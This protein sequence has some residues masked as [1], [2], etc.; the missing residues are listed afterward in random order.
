MGWRAGRGRHTGPGDGKLFRENRRGGTND[1]RRQG[2]KSLS[3]KAVPTILRNSFQRREPDPSYGFLSRS[4]ASRFPETEGS[5]DWVAATRRGHAS[6]SSQGRA[7]QRVRGTE[8]HQRRE[9]V[10]GKGRLPESEPPLAF[11]CV[12]ATLR[13]FSMLT[14]GNRSMRHPARRAFGLSSGNRITWP[15][16]RWLSRSPP[17]YLSSPAFRAGRTQSGRPCPPHTRCD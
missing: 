3:A 1:D 10:G 15:A 12:S 7:S 8:N 2:Q 9:A 16:R 11:L 4:Y 6:S 13:C 5:L 17:E 14:R